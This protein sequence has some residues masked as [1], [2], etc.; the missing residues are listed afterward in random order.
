MGLRKIRIANLPPE[1]SDKTLRDIMS[2]YGDVKDVTEEQWS[3]KYRYPVSNGIRIVELQLKQHIP[4]HM[5]IVGQSALITYKGQ[6]ITCYGCNEAGHQ[7]GE[8]PH[9]T[10]P[11]PQQ[12]SHTDSWAQIL[13]NGPRTKRQ[14]EE[15][16]ER[17]EERGGSL[18][19]HNNTDTNK[20]PGNGQKQSRQVPTQPTTQEATQDI[21]S[22]RATVVIDVPTET[23]AIG[24]EKC[25]MQGDEKGKEEGEGKQTSAVQYRTWN[26]NHPMIV[27]IATPASR[28]MTNQWHRRTRKPL[29]LM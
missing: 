4:S 2:K 27:R 1:V 21:H 15:K 14:D 8:C 6:P 20:I 28:Q 9:R 22:N 23:T 19:A 24:S 3:Q 7:Y 11:P 5:L 17:S 29:S 12:P 10:A 13:V 18:D 26:G 25:T 16:R